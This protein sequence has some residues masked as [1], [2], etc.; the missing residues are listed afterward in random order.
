[1][2]KNFIDNTKTQ[3]EYELVIE[4]KTTINTSFGIYCSE[5]CQHLRKSKM[6]C[7]LFNASIGKRN[8]DIRAIR[9]DECLDCTVI[10]M[11]CKSLGLPDFFKRY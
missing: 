7:K 2:K 11:K 5:D 10:E 9:C 4:T 3:G 1:M 8:S 6:I